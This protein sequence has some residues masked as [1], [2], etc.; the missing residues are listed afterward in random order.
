MRYLV[1]SV[2]LIQRVVSLDG[3]V[4]SMLMSPFRGLVARACIV[5]EA[6]LMVVDVPALV[7][8]GHRKTTRLTRRENSSI[9]YWLS[10]WHRKQQLDRCCLSILHGRKL[11][12]P[13][14][15]CSFVCKV[16]GLK[17]GNTV[18]V[19]S[20]LPHVVQQQEY[21]LAW[22]GGFS[23]II[24]RNPRG[25]SCLQIQ[26]APVPQGEDLTPC[27]PKTLQNSMTASVIPQDGVFD[28]CF[29][30]SR[31]WRCTRLPKGLSGSVGA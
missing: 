6:L 21:D 27:V 1:D 9:A 20:L 10:S 16:Q 22:R 15:D 2:S 17:Q 7:R 26:L 18:Y 30:V 28:R 5:E 31:P 8:A 3:V 23:R 24:V 13:E 4:F 12:V 29:G 11:H 14:L 19:Q 25:S